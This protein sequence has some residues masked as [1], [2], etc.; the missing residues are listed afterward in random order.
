MGKDYIAG[1]NLQRI[2]QISPRQMMQNLNEQ[3]LCRYTTAGSFTPGYTQG[4]TKSCVNPC[5]NEFG[6]AASIARNL[7]R[8][9]VNRLAAG[10]IASE[11]SYMR[12]AIP[13]R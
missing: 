7:F 3:G 11:S 2:A 10:N 12:D 6:F 13:T 1:K 9:G 4:V 8:T 5:M